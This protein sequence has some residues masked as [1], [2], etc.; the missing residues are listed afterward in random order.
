MAHCRVNYK[1][2]D[3]ATIPINYGVHV[4][5]WF[6]DSAKTL[7]DE[8]TLAWIGANRDSLTR[9]AAPQSTRLFVTSW[10]NPQPETPID[11]LDILSDKSVA[12]LV[13]VALAGEPLED[14]GVFTERVEVDLLEGLRDG[15]VVAGAA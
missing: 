11:S 10:T 1:G 12:S 6:G 2:G 9:G 15:G 13:C 4:E 7:L 14:A 5:N 8:G 3:A